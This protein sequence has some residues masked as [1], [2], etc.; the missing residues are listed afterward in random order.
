M[1]YYKKAPWWFAILLI[2]VSVP[3][4]WME[5]EAIKVLNESNWMTND[6]TTWLYP[7]YVIISAFSAW[8]CYSQRKTLAWILLLLIMITDLALLFFILN[9]KIF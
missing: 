8:F 3:A 9:H 2:I 6:L 7:A 4:L 5:S 1:N